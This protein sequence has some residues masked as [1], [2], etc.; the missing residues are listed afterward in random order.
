M[1]DKIFQIGDQVNYQ[2]LSNRIL[3]K[4]VGTQETS[5]G[6]KYQI[7]SI[8]QPDQRFNSGNWVNPKNLSRVDLGTGDQKPTQTLG[9]NIFLAGGSRD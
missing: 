1:E 7:E 3:V 6:T 9:F 2:I 5:V 4:I 8:A